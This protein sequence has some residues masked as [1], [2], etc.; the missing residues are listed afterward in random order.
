M[1]APPVSA[2]ADSI[3]SRVLRVIE[4]GNADERSALVKSAFSEKAVSTD[5]ARFDHFLASMHEEG[6]PYTVSKVER[7]GRHA[8]VT[9]RSS[10]AHR[11]ATL[12]ISTD[13]TN[14]PRLGNVD[15]LSS[16]NAVLDSLIWP[17]HKPRSNTEV[18]RI[19]SANLERLAKA[20]ALA[21]VVYIAA[22][23][24]VIY[25]HAFGLADRENDVPN[26]CCRIPRAWATNGA[27]QNVQSPD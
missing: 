24:S 4:S 16:S 18:A 8:L 5:S 22:H 21:G 2:P 1:A 3:V 9:L 15:I 10:R 27:R 17:T 11:V 19:V 13:R 20:D 7:M 6:A 12:M 26:I 25:E 23:D 14:P